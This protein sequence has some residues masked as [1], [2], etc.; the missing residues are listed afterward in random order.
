MVERQHFPRFSTGSLLP[1]SMEFLE[2]RGY[3]SSGCATFQLKDGAA[4]HWNGVNTAIYFPDK[5]TPAQAPVSGA[6]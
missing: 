3:S 5:S 1:Q 2:E 4:F 6:P